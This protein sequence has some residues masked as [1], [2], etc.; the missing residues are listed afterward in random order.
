MIFF[1]REVD[2][3]SCDH[4]AMVEGPP[5]EN[6]KAKET[7]KAM[8]L[9]YKKIVNDVDKAFTNA[10]GWFN[11]PQ[12]GLTQE[13]YFKHRADAFFEAGCPNFETF[14]VGRGFR[15]VDYCDVVFERDA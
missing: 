14:L 6:D 5:M 8:H 3:D 15:T 12:G 7:F 2:Y 10:F 1:I 11:A 13:N 9:E 4:M